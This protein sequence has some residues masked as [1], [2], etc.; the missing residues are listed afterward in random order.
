MA[1][2]TRPAAGLMRIAVDVV[3]ADG[4]DACGGPGA[5]A[6]VDRALE[7]GHVL[8]AGAVVRVGACLRGGTRSAPAARGGVTTAAATTLER[9][10]SVDIAG[11]G[12]SHAPCGQGDPGV[13][14]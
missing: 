14:G 12:S 10:D 13:G 8:V 6:I 11:E 7:V 2:A 3:G 4:V 1:A 9:G 5:N